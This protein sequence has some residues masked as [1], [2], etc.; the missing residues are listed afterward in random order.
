MTSN[1]HVGMVQQGIEQPQVRRRNLDLRHGGNLLNALHYGLDRRQRNGLASHQRHPQGVLH[2]GLA[3]LGRQLQ[4]LQVF[5]HGPLP[6]VLAAQGIVGHAKMTRGEEVLTV[7]VVL[8]RAR[9]ADQRVDDMPIIDGML[10]APAQTR[11]RLHFLARV[12]HFHVLHADH[13]IH[14]LADQAAMHRVG[15]LLHLDRAALAHR[16]ARQPPAAFQPPWRQLPQQRLLFGK[17]LLPIRVAARHQTAKK[18]PVLFRAGEVAAATQTQGLVHR[19]LEMPVR[20]F[21]VAVLMRLADV[22]PLTLQTVVRQEVLVTLL[23]FPPLG[24][25]VHR[26]RKAV[27]AVATGSSS[28]LPKR[29]LQPFAQ[30]LEGLRRADRDRLP[31]GIGQREVI[32]QV[33]KGLAAESHLQTIHVREVGRRQ[34]CG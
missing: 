33:G 1:L 3:L 22:D 27:A 13:H 7:H 25:I 34:V 32:H 20:G 8:E 5:T 14:L 21:H 2:R 17:R 30:R 29:V 19:G 26:R 23:K 11:H 12:P 10:V 9:L 15:V 16:D 24:E 18:L 4:N 6:R 28:Q 31:V